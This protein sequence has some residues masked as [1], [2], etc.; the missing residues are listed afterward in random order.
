[1]S[2]V[3]Y[4]CSPKIELD[5]NHLEKCSKVSCGCGS[6]FYHLARF[7]VK[8]GVTYRQF[9]HTVVSLN[10]PESACPGDHVVATREAKVAIE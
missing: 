10:R 8:R 6:D 9:K 2:A 7:I 4:L 1:M 5:V 3:I